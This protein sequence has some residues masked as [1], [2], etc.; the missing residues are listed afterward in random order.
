M[1]RL[2]SAFAALPLLLSLSAHAATWVD[3]GAT[4]EQQKIKFDSERIQR[5]GDAVTVAIRVDYPATQMI[6]FSPKTYVSAERIYHFQCASKQFIVA[7]V[8]M[9]DKEGATVYDFDSSKSP[10]GSPQPQA[11]PADKSAD[12]LAFDAACAYKKP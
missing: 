6:P 9:F 7:S 1:K 8:K 12:R 2:I 5:Q 3:V 10:F 11:I 4:A